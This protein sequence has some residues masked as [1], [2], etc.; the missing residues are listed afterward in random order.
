MRELLMLKKRSALVLAL[1]LAIAV[2]AIAGA[3]SLAQ[4]PNRYS[5]CPNFHSDQSNHRSAFCYRRGDRGGNITMIQQ[6]LSPQYYR[7]REDGIF[8]SV[9][10]Q[11][12]KQ[13]QRRHGLTPDGIVGSSTI[14]TLCDLSLR[15]PSLSTP[16]R[17]T[18]SQVCH[19]GLTSI[20]E[21][22]N[23][24][25][26]KHYQSDHSKT[27]T[28]QSVIPRALIRAMQQDLSQHIYEH[29]PGNYNSFSGYI[30]FRDLNSDRRP[31]AIVYPEIGIPCSNR[32]C[33][34]FIYTPSGRDYRRISAD[35]PNGYSGVFGSRNQP[36]VGL[37]PTRNRGWQDLATRLFN[38]DTRT[39]EWVRI[40]YD[41][42]GYRLLDSATVPEPST[43]LESAS[44]RVINFNILLRSRHP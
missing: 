3:V 38:Y 32:S 35:R 40:R 13:F 9:L 10:E 36:S 37:L 21:D 26:F 11:A 44:L 7:G 34:I 33:A 25:D 18:S 14:A 6:R 31:E 20:D 24:V 41:R 5:H 17:D 22:G 15:D 43:K 27:Q 28:K 19:V 1:G 4:P 39:E 29:E 16:Q 8:G 30:F 42:Q 23:S 12:V 2:N